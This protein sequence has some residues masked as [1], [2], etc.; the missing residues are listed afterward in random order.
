M[1]NGQSGFQLLKRNLLPLLRLM[2]MISVLIIQNKDLKG[3]LMF[4]QMVILVVQNKQVRRF[5]LMGQHNH[6][7]SMQA[8]D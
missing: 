1:M 3:L 6:L 5:C 7:M 8:G 2:I 4:Y